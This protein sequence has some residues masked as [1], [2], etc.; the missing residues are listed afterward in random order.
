MT[1]RR[2]T[3]LDD[4]T[5]QGSASLDGTCNEGST[6]D[7]EPQSVL[8]PAVQR[9]RYV[10]GNDLHVQRPCAPPKCTNMSTLGL[11]FCL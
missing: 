11:S 2:K 1:S 8:Q 6:D 5:T 3:F 10:M 9:S 4:K 7:E